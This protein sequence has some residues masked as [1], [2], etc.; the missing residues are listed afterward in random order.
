VPTCHEVAAFSF[1]L[2]PVPGAPANV[3]HIAPFDLLHKLD[4]LDGE[5]RG[6]GGA[7]A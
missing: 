7:S 4:V 3:G 2:L 6:L 1:A 5:R